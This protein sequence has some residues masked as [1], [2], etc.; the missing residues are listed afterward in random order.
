MQRYKS[1]T[2]ILEMRVVSRKE[3][4]TGME[5]NYAEIVF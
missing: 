1:K 2:T 5:I 4:N 3:R